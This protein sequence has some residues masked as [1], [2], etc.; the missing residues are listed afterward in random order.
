MF[1]LSTSHIH[2][3]CGRGGFIKLI[4]SGLPK[5][6][7]LCGLALIWVSGNE[8]DNKKRRMLALF[9]IMFYIMHNGCQRAP[10]HTMTGQ[11]T[12]DTCKSSTLI[13]SFNHFGLSVS[14]DE[15]FRF[16]YHNDM[17]CITVEK[18]EKFPI[19]LQT[20]IMNLYCE[21]VTI[22]WLFPCHDGIC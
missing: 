19:Y 3:Q 15:I 12:H 20:Y 16:R 4:K 7:S 13:K 8:S 10:L 5:R 1:V 11:A 21:F 14:Y 18:Q 2:A 17:A 22:Q 9:Q 6:A